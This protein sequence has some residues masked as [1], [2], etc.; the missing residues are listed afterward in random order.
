MFWVAYSP[1]GENSV[2]T[3]LQGGGGGAGEGDGGGGE[4]DGGG[5]LGDGG[6]GE[7]DG[8]G[9]EGDGGGGEGDIHPLQWRTSWSCSL[10]SMRTAVSRVSSFAL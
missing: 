5:G 1:S 10:N 4:G 6:G 3:P 7:G 2:V 9:G 8:G